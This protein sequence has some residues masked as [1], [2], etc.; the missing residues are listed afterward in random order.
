MD[1]QALYDKFKTCSRVS[2]DTRSLQTGDLFFAIKGD[3]FDG[4]KYAQ[5]A[6]DQGAKFAVIDD[7]KLADNPQYILVDDCLK[8]LQAL[9]NYHRKQF[10]GKVLAITGSNG[11]TTTKELTNQVL[12]TQY[13]V[14]CTQGNFNNHL[15]VPLT[16]LSMPLDT[17]IAI[18]EMGANHL[19]EIAALCLIAEPTHGIITNLGSAHE[20]EFGGRENI[21]RAKSELFDFVLKNEGHV[22]IN[23]DDKVLHNM[24]KR[25]EHYSSYP[26]TLIQLQSSAPYV[27]Y[28]D[29]NNEPHHTHLIGAY[30]Y[31]NIAAAVTIADFFDINPQKIHAAID[32]FIPENNR[33]QI[34]KIGSNTVILDAYNANPDSCKVALINLSEFDSNSKIAILGD[35]KELGEYSKKEHQ[36]II[37]LANDL[38]LNTSYFVGEDYANVSKL[39]YQKMEDLISYLQKHPIANSVVLLKGSRSM[40]MEQLIKIDELWS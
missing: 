1:I 19:G 20:G 36:N 10:N 39:A 3:N 8:T 31:L 17:E 23:I 30:N 37:Q 9:A 12:Q 4:N 32:S 29:T 40:A 25:F 2:I 24:T 15:G 6:I 22:F 14:H 34:L 35:M 16:L 5:K 21:V 26:N 18:I 28:L 7:A 33:S 38:R 27:I 11:K 13:K